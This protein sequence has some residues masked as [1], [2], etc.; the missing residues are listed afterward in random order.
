MATA[1]PVRRLR[2][3]EPRQASNPNRV[4]PHAPSTSPTRARRRSSSSPTRD[5]AARSPRS[6][7]RAWIRRLTRR[8]RP[9]RHRFTSRHRA[10]HRYTLRCEQPAAS[11][12]SSTVQPSSTI[13]RHTALAGTAST[14]RYRATSRV[15]LGRGGFIPPRR[16]STRSRTPARS[17]RSRRPLPAAPPHRFPPTRPRYDPVRRVAAPP[18]PADRRATCTPAAARRD[19]EICAI[20][21]DQRHPRRQR[22]DERARYFHLRSRI[23]IF[24]SQLHHRRAAAHA[25][26]RALHDLIAAVAARRP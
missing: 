22:R 19:R 21:H 8:R 4:A 11:A 13:R 16:P 23:R 17:P 1:I 24:E 5:G 18:P 14:W 9:I 20:V 6:S 7:P 25:R 3:L 12:A 15:S 26:E 2:R 10:N